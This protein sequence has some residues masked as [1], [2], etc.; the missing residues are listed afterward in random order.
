MHFQTVFGIDV[1]Q[2]ISAKEYA[3]WKKYCDTFGPIWWKRNDW[4]FAGLVSMT[5]AMAYQKP[6]GT[7]EALL[8]FERVKHDP[9]ANS[10]ALIGAFGMLPPDEIQELKDAAMM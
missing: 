9:L 10:I 4:N 3:R 1:F 7:K 6:V 8:I 5:S 2:R